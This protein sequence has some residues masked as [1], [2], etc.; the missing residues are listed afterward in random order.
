MFC[1]RCGAE[2]DEGSRY[3]ASC[4]ADLPKQ[5]GEG[6]AEGTDARPA[7]RERIA[8]LA[9]RDRRARI[10]TLGTVAAILI[11]VAAFL[12]LDSSS[13]EAPDASQDAY[14]KALDVACIGHKREIAAAQGTAL[15]SGSLTAVG[16]Y[17]DSLVPI[18]GE[19]RLEL[20]R[21]GVPA[22]HADS[23]EA[24]GAALLEVEIEA[25]TL[26]RLAREADPKKVTEAA[27][28]VDAATTNVEAAISSLGLARC[29]R[30]AVGQGQVVSQ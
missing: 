8:R 29:G 27:A 23:V 3:C 24:L 13:D 16:S 28:R 21:G 26:A 9:G 4:G 30:L 12:A 1:P 19:W 22:D 5:K 11:A 14:T 15:T 7:L 18:V 25:G 10:V 6:S 17:A 2:S 20:S